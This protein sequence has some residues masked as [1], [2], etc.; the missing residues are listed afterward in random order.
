MNEGRPMLIKPGSIEDLIVDWMEQGLS[1]HN[2]TIIVNEHQLD[3]GE[4]HVG[5]NDV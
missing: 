2:T 5:R 4:I 1:F 3:K